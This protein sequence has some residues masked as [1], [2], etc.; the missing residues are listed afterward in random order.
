MSDGCWILGRDTWK[1]LQKYDFSLHI[2]GKFTTL[3]LIYKAYSRETFKFTF[4]LHTHI[5]CIIKLQNIIYFK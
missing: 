2:H 4:L 1:N 3:I 5:I